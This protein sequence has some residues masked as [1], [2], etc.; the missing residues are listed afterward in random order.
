MRQEVS[1]YKAGQSEVCINETWVKD[2]PNIL[3]FSLNRV[4]YDKQQMKLVKDF[5]KFEFDKEIH[6][7][8]NLEGNIGRINGVR[9]RTRLLKEEIKALRSQLEACKQDNILDNMTKTVEFL[10]GQIAAKTG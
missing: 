4:K 2:P 9:Q 7:D 10:Q 1:D 8:Q 3:I 5:K 6:V